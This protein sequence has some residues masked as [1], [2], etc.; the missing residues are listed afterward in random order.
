MLTEWNYVILKGHINCYLNTKENISIDFPLYYYIEKGFN[1]L[2]CTKDFAHNRAK[3]DHSQKKK[4]R[5]LN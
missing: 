4:K 3:R 2:L 5:N 1:Y